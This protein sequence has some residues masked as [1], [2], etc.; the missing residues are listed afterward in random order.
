MYLQRVIG[1]SATAAGLS[2][3]V[4]MATL[5]A[6]AG[7]SSHLIA[8]H[9]RYKIV[10][11]IGLAVAI[12]SVIWLAWQV[13]DISPLGFELLLAVLG[14]GFGPIAPLSTTALQNTVAMHQFGTAIGTLNFTRT[15]YATILVAVSGALVSDLD[16]AAGGTIAATGPLAASG[17]QMVF[18][19]AAVSLGI[20]FV[21]TVLLEEKPLR[22]GA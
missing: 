5:N 22:T 15:L 7:L 18:V 20:A 3:M 17:F 4:L 6:S 1:M 12:G 8:R 21:A 14:I 9:T 11:L 13:R 10:P 16:A 19:A 2:L